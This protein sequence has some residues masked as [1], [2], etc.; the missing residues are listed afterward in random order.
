VVVVAFVWA[1]LT[2]EI[3]HVGG[4][5]GHAVGLEELLVFLEHTIEPRKKLLGAMVSMD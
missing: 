3:D 1:R 5:E 2:R 4:E